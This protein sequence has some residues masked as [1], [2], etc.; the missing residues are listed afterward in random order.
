MIK[1]LFP[2]PAPPLKN[3]WDGWCSNS[4]SFSANSQCN[5]LHSIENNIFQKKKN[6]LGNNKLSLF[7]DTTGAYS[8][9]HC[10][11]NLDQAS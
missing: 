11:S 2:P 10:P 7:V 8:H 1:K 3:I 4:L 9:Y 6:S 5:A